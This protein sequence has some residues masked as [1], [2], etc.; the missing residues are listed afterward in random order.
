MKV[1]LP[2][3]I[4]CIIGIPLVSAQDDRRANGNPGSST[5]IVINQRSLVAG[6][7]VGTEPSTN[8]YA[9]SSAR[10]DGKSSKR[11]KGSK[12]ASDKSQMTI[13]KSEKGKIVNDGNTIA[14]EPHKTIAKSKK[15]SSAKAEKS[16]G[17]SPEFDNAGKSKAAKSKTGKSKTSRRSS[18]TDGANTA[19]DKAGKSKT[20][21]ESSNTDDA[22]T[23]SDKAGK[24]KT[25]KVSSNADDASTSFD[26]ITSNK[27]Q[28]PFTRPLQFAPPVKKSG[29]GK[30]AKHGNTLVDEQFARPLQFAPLV[31]KSG[32]GKS[33]KYGNTLVDEPF[34]RPL[35]FA[36]LVEKSG[37]GKSAKY[38]NTLV[39]EPHK[40]FA[41]SKK[42]SITK[43]GKSGGE[44]SAFGKAGK[45]KS[46][47]ESSNTNG[48]SQAYDKAG[49][50][51][52]SKENESIN[53]DTPN[54]PNAGSTNNTPSPTPQPTCNTQGDFD[55]CIAIDASG[56]VCFDSNGM[57]PDWSATECLKCSPSIFCQDMGLDQATCCRNF[58]DV[59]G[60]SSLLVNSMEEDFP[61]VE[62]SF[63]VVQFGKDSVVESE[64]SSSNQTLLVLDGMEYLGGSTNHASAIEACQRTFSSSIADSRQQFILL[65]T[66][67]V[68]TW[69]EGNP[70]GT[71]EV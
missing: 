31:E 48:A 46:S 23:A 42:G 69:P 66:D 70:E 32:K 33:A 49:N 7:E 63:S 25:S 24:S 1:S 8:V 53:I 56:S 67:G 18:N 64:L 6:S 57:V 22:N 39:D 41:K 45:S 38:G 10:R 47:K 9:R 26:K 37:K 61:T 44:S 59:K 43:S 20:S 65:I 55:L 2:F 3:G 50:N 54:A 62:K 19:S 11:G 34:A 27:S 29:K 71:A 12:S 28:S 17:A 15:E 58:A 51:T 21:K 16:E 36:P 52:I 14:D 13:D 68:S 30:S 4:F 35:Q 40:I 60:F 5:G